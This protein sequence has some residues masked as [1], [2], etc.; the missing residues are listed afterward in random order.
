MDCPFCDLDSNDR[1]EIILENEFCLFL[2]E[3]QEVLIGSGMIVPKEH[4]E[5]VFEL[6]E[7]EWMA[8]F[9]LLK[10]AQRRI[11]AEYKPNG[12]NIGWNCGSVAGQEVFHAQLHVIPRYYDEPLAGKGIR[13]WMK[14]PANRRDM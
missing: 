5:T 13:Y 11:D 9:S 12:Y 6:S 7:Q 3:P 10:R 4:R 14:Q 2:Q 1:Q 8:T